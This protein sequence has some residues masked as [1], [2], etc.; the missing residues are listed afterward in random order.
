MHPAT[1][2]LPVKAG[3]EVALCC[4]AFEQSETQ[5]SAHPL[6]WAAGRSNINLDLG[7]S[8]IKD[9][10]TAPYPMQ[11]TQG[12]T[13]FAENLFIKEDSCAKQYLFSQLQ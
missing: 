4:L 11:L 8:E 13:H 12:A 2:L 1:A 9:I 10:T 3:V 7:F 5:K 6:R